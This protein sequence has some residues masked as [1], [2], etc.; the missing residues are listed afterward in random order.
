MLLSF[1]PYIYGQISDGV[2]I[3]EHRRRFPDEPIMAYMYISK[4][5][6]SI[7]GI[8]IL[9]NRHSLEDWIKQFADNPSAVKRIQEYRKKYNYAMEI[10]SFYETNE[11]LLDDLKRDIPGFIAPQSYYYLDNKPVLLDYIENNIVWKKKTIQND[12]SRLLPEQVCVH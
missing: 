7:K 12:F 1:K 2:K 11:I 4:P 5:V 10:S 6:R 9:N 3:F 8:V